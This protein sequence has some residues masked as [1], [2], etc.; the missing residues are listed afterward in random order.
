MKYYKIIFDDPTE[1]LHD[2]DYIKSWDDDNY[3]DVVVN[4]EIQETLD[5]NIIQTT[6][7]FDWKYIK[8]SLFIECNEFGSP[9]NEE[10]ERL[11]TNK[12][13][14]VTLIYKYFK[15]NNI[16]YGSFIESR[17]II[18]F[19]CPICQKDNSKL[20]I[21]I[22]T[23]KVK[24]FSQNDCSDHDF[25]KITN[26]LITLYHNPDIFTIFD[27]IN[28]FNGTLV[29]SSSIEYHGKN[30][31]NIP[32]EYNFGIYYTKFG[33]I[34]RYA[35]KLKVGK[36]TLV[37]K[38][39]KRLSKILLYPDK[40]IFVNGSV[41]LE[42]IGQIGD[43]KMRRLQTI[44]A[45]TSSREFKKYLQSY[46]KENTWFD[47]EPDDVTGIHKYIDKISSFKKL[48]IEKC[49]DKFGWYENKFS[50]Y[51]IKIFS[52][53]NDINEM[54]KAFVTTG[55][56][57]KWYQKINE[58]RENIYFETQ[59][60]TSLSAPLISILNRQPI[61]LHLHGL[62]S[63]AKTAGM[64]AIS[65]FWGNPTMLMKNFRFTLVGFENHLNI[66]NNVPV[67]FNDSQHLDVKMSKESILYSAFEGVGKTK[68]KDKNG[69]MTTRKWCTN[70]ITNGEKPLVM[71]S[72]KE[73]A[74][75]RCLEISGIMIDDN[76][77][78]SKCY[79]FFNSNYGMQG[80][81][82]IERIKTIDKNQGLEDIYYIL[83]KLNNDI[84][85]DDHIQQVATLTY[86]KS[87][88]DN[89]TLDEAIIFG[90]KILKLLPMKK[91]AYSQTEKIMNYLRSFYMEHQARFDHKNNLPD[92]Y[93][94]L[95]DNSIVFFDNVINKIITDNFDEDV[96]EFRK[97]V[98]D[99][100]YL[101][102]DNKGNLKQIKI[103]GK[104]SRPLQFRGDIFFGDDKI[105]EVDKYISHKL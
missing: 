59:F 80:K 75:K 88:Y 91:T 94:R 17:N 21:S 3:I 73:G 33:I 23:F 34:K 27:E 96:R 20:W 65:S 8:P 6:K 83:D 48:K 13:R 12:S 69:N 76:L 16:K 18:K 57:E 43:K 95:L 98:R 100:E 66:M 63:T 26:D 58:L 19:S 92:M 54:Q 22:F 78:A 30:F 31:Y 51:D 15:D 53:D 45:F 105:I 46:G 37:Y 87:I 9:I 55:N 40:K 102:T 11:I 47:G 64:V 28:E 35:Y 67:F 25:S 1:I 93:G 10:N 85:I 97:K 32:E 7:D 29:D 101:V 5:N 84:N 90:N 79:G 44:E 41:E 104:N 36:Q 42:L 49:S 81:Q 72:M 99:L 89:M 14:R 39:D 86:C 24:T 4:R 2:D 62:S 56:Y 61:W 52:N 50:P 77:E 60:L 68:G 82:W 74:I 71:D 38:K 103:N 70:V